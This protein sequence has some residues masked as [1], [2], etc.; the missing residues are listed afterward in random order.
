MSIHNRSA[1]PDSVLGADVCRVFLL[2]LGEKN[3]SLLYCSHDVFLVMKKNHSLIDLKSPHGFPRDSELEA[4]IAEL[5]RTH[6][7]STSE[8]QSPGNNM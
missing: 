4:E 7:G 5:V 6:P 8:V 1:I 3:M 2:A